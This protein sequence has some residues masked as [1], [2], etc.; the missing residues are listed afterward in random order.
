MASPLFNSPTPIV[1]PRNEKTIV[2]LGL[3]SLLCLMF[4]REPLLLRIGNAP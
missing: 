1:S 3:A 4:G 2:F